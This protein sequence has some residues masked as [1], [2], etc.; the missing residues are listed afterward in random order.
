V[1]AQDEEVSFDVFEAIKHPSGAKECFRVD[2]LDEVC[3]EQEKRIH[4]FDPLM[5]ILAID[6]IDKGEE[7][8]VQKCWEKFG[9]AREIPKNSVQRQR[10]PHGA[11]KLKDPESHRCRNVSAWASRESLRRILQRKNEK[12]RELQLSPGRERS[13]P[14]RKLRVL[15]GVVS[16]GRERSRPERKLRVLTRVVSPGQN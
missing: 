1:C 16:P 2:V 9:K 3:A 10:R 14:E 8:E 7:R 11:V 6:G 15:T 5:K 4:A 13:R 12:N